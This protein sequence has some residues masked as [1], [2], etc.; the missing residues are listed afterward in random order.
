MHWRSS[1]GRG[2]YAVFTAGITE[3]KGGVPVPAL[4]RVPRPPNPAGIQGDIGRIGGILVLYRK[5]PHFKNSTQYIYTHTH[6]YNILKAKLPNGRPLLFCFGRWCCSC[7]GSRC[8]SWHLTLLIQEDTGR[9]PPLVIEKSMVHNS[10]GL[11]T[12]KGKC[13]HK[14][15]VGFRLT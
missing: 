5:E 2:G 11:L 4:W 9:S 10:E 3:A 15:V 1:G 7:N 6:I 8:L 14:W 13:M 12:L